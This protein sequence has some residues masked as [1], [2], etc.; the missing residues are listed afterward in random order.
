[1]LKL[2][3]FMNRTFDNHITQ[4]I[5]SDR[6]Y[7]AESNKLCGIDCIC[8]IVLYVDS[9]QFFLF[10][11]E[12]IYIYIFNFSFTPFLSVAAFK[13]KEQAS[14]K[15]SSWQMP[16]R[17]ML[18]FLSHSQGFFR[19]SE[20][21]PWR[22]RLIFCFW[23]LI[24]SL[25]RRRHKKVTTELKLMSEPLTLLH[26]PFIW[27]PGMGHILFVHCKILVSFHWIPIQYFKS[28]SQG[29][30]RKTCTKEQNLNCQSWTYLSYLC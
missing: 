17:I 21:L 7:L 1:M 25:N 10:S 19:N 14:H 30:P 20:F 22:P 29:L 23:L 16:M 26:E 9:L 18:L 4:A 6:K 24:L 15:P 3:R 5:L 12:Y 13:K 27:F 8:S 11:E 28:I 2:K